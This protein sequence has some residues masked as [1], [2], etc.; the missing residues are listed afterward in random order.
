MAD[1]ERIKKKLVNESGEGKERYQ[2]LVDLSP[3]PIVILQD[4]QYKF[5]SPAFTEVFG[6]SKEEVDEGLSFFQLVQEHDREA[7]RRQYEDRITGNQVPRTYRIDLISKAGRV[8]P[9]ETSATLIHYNGKPADLVLIR[10]ITERIR[11][12]EALRKVHEEMEKK[13][14]E[15]TSELEEVNAALR[16]L[17][18]RREE[19]KTELEERILTNVKK[20][21][22]P[23]LE[24]LKSTGLTT[25]QSAYVDTLE[26]NLTDI[27]SPFAHTLSSTYVNLTPTEIQIADLVKEGR[28]T[29]EI[30]EMLNSSSRTVESHRKNIRKK[31]G[32][33]NKKTSLRSHLLSM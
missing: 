1:H 26:S 2:I 32:I 17:L 31:I 7:V 12:E 13:V 15:R 33:A 20:L 19:D 6:Y 23:G 22:I 24:K 14:E 27:I 16:A 30:A 10:D 29:K 28:T 8:I 11:A 9:C 18:K 5:V 25:K 4:N 3:E 21:V